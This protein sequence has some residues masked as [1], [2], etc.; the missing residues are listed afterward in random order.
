MRQC[1]LD[2]SVS[3][4]ALCLSVSLSVS[5][6]QCSQNVPNAQL[7]S[8]Y[9]LIT[10]DT[11]ATGSTVTKRGQNVNQ[12]QTAFVRLFFF[13]PLGGGMLNAPLVIVV[14]Q[15]NMVIGVLMAISLLTSCCFCPFMSCCWLDY[16]KDI[17]G[18]FKSGA[19][20]LMNDRN[21]V[22]DH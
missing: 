3:T 18:F 15:S 5:D 4:T 1:A 8:H 22:S 13:P 7:H 17:I 2:R 21:K 16:I 10:L 20:Q 11:T 19:S 14:I 6:S 9:L 12:L